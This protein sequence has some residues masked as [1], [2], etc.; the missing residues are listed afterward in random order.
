MLAHLKIAPGSYCI[1]QNCKKKK[2]RTNWGLL[3]CPN[4]HHLCF[5]REFNQRYSFQICLGLQSTHGMNVDEGRRL[6][7][8]ASSSGSGT[9]TSA[10]SR[11]QVVS[12]VGAS[13]LGLTCSSL[14][15]RLSSAPITDTIQNRG[16]I[17]QCCTSLKKN[18]SYLHSS[19]KLDMWMCHLFQSNKNIAEPVNC[20]WFQVECSFSVLQLW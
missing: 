15:A 3:T 4:A 8:E 18:H 10:S 9:T 12:V 17:R 11:L 14:L 13:L 20:F 7:L 19:S 1:F 2:E 5:D 16:N 6:F